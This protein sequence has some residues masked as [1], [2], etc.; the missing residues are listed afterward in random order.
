MKKKIFTIV[1][2]LVMMITMMPAMAMTSFA[3]DGMVACP[4]CGGDGCTGCEE[5]SLCHGTHSCGT[6]FDG[7]CMVCFGTGKDVNACICHGTGVCYMCN[8][9]LTC[10]ICQG[11]D[12]ECFV[13]NGTGQCQACKDNPGVC[14]SCHGQLGNCPACDGTKAC[15]D[16][17]GTG[18]C[19][20]CVKCTNCDGTGLVPSSHTVK[21]VLNGHGAKIADMEVNGTMEAPAAPTAYGWIFGGWYKDSNFTDKWDFASDK[22]TEDIT[23]YAKWTRAVCM[24]GAKTS[25]SKA[26]TLKWTKVKNATKYVV[27]GNKCGKKFKKLTTVKK[28]NYKVKKIKGSKLK[29]HKPYK[30]YVVAYNG[31]KKIAKS[32]AITFITG[33]TQGKYANAKSIT[34]NVKK[35]TLVQGKKKTL[36]VKTKIYKNKKQIKKKYGAKT[37][38]ISSNPKVATVTTKG[39]IKAKAPGSATVYVQNIGGLYKTVKVTVSSVSPV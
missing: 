28:C 18:K 9:S 11:N 10:F 26:V 37:R 2:S 39:V 4:V 33:K 27:Y 20:N 16:C 3:D 30:F 25:G 1:L 36:K 21:F 32:K 34:V 14:D 13:C 24:L 15:S 22:V 8:G 29:A 12:D 19:P 38:Y 17:N 31:N 5:C 7:E 23:L 35:V 6:C